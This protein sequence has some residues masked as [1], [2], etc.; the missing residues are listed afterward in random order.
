MRRIRSWLH[1]TVS[2]VV[3]LSE[4]QQPSSDLELNE[5][6]DRRNSVQKRSSP[7]Y[8]TLT[9]SGISPA[10]KRARR[11]KSEVCALCRSTD[12]A[13]AVSIHFDGRPVAT[14]WKPA[15][16]ATRT[17]PSRENQCSTLGGLYSCHC[18][19]ANR[20]P[21]FAVPRFNQ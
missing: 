2:L 7:R 5:H 18:W 14:A 4:I 20:G 16:C 6:Y 13:C 17:T 12:L 11:L 15:A 19:P 21:A 8:G 3:A 1:R 9:R 10:A